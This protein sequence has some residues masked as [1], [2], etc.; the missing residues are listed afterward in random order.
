MGKFGDN[1]KKK[2]SI[3]KVQYTSSI[4]QLLADST[5]LGSMINKLEGAVICWMLASRASRKKQT[6]GNFYFIYH[7]T[8]KTFCFVGMK[9]DG[10]AAR[11]THFHSPFHFPFY[12]FFVLFCCFLFLEYH[13]PYCATK[14]VA[15]VCAKRSDTTVL[16]TRDRLSQ[17]YL[18][19]KNRILNRVSQGYLSQ[20][21]LY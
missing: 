3:S 8:Y 4:V 15:A 11:T 5:P 1:E 7:G 6:K 17:G 9:M 19:A 21:L 12:T 10:T 16:S 14:T 20:M 13:L 2:G 18:R